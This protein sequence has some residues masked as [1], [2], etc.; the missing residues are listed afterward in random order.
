MKI[1]KYSTTAT[2]AIHL[3]YRT[4]VFF[5]I[6]KLKEKQ[7]FYVLLYNILL[8][9]SLQW[10]NHSGLFSLLYRLRDFKK[11]TNLVFR[12]PFIGTSSILLPEV[13]NP[14]NDYEIGEA[15]VE[16]GEEGADSDGH[17]TQQTQVRIILSI[18][19]RVEWFGTFLR[20]SK[21]DILRSIRFIFRSSNKKICKFSCKWASQAWQSFTFQNTS[22]TLN[23]HILSF[24]CDFLDPCDCVKVN[25]LYFPPADIFVQNKKRTDVYP[26]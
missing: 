6:S 7:S 16:G 21:M 8:I 24:L 2:H 13:V 18:N 19:S 1:I 26:F 9:I 3:K 25:I 5:C 14:A 20:F 11:I 15:G 22:G 10:P 12:E 17:Q 23:V 4:K